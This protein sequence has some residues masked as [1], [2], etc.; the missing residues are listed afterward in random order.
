MI[1]GERNF[2]RKTKIEV[3]V[4]GRVYRVKADY[5]SW[6]VYRIVPGQKT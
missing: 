6:A 4:G 1:E 5:H 2:G 3:K